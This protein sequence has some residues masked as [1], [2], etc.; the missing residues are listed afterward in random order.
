MRFLFFGGTWHGQYHEAN[1]SRRFIVPVK[2]REFASVDD[3]RLIDLDEVWSYR[4]PK[5]Y[6]NHVYRLARLDFE[7]A[8]VLEEI[9]EG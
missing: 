7:T 6:K 8:Y 2:E 4:R 9:N 5:S 1:G 3:F